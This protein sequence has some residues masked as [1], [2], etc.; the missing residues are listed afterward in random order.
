MPDFVIGEH[1]KFYPDGKVGID[2]PLCKA[3]V[4]PPEFHLRRAEYDDPQRSLKSVMNSKV[5]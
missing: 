3:P 2:Y 4:L 5:I 1:R